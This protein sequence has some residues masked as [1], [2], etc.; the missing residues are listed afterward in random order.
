MRRL[1]AAWGGAGERQEPGGGLGGGVG[2]EEEKML[3]C[4]ETIALS[5]V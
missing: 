1:G 2:E 5:N 4:A 3:K